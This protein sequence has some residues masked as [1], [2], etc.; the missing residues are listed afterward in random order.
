MKILHVSGAMGWGGNEQQMID[1]IP[2]LNKLDVVNIVF[3]VNRSILHLEC[4]S[5]GI[6]FI[7]AKE[8]KLNKLV[9]YRYL[10]SI[11]REIKPDIIH[12][13]TS[14]SLTVY[15]ISDLFFG[16]KTKAV[17]SKKGMGNSSS[18]L[19]KFK[20]NYIN[21]K[22]IICVSEAVKKSFSTIISKNNIHKLKVVYDGINLNRATIKNNINIRESYKIADD[23]FIIGNIANHV[24]AKDLNTLINTMNC[25]VNEMGIRNIHL[26]QV[27]KFSNKLTPEIQNLISVYKLHDFVTLTDFQPNALGFL[28][29]FDLYVMSSEREGLP[30][31][32]FEAFLKKIPVVSTKAGGIPEAIIHGFNGYLSEIR[33]YNNL[34]LN[35]QDLL[36]NQTRREEFVERSNTIFFEKFTAENT[37]KNT[38]KIYKA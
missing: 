21:I 16:L 38:L 25:L 33:D 22:T 1:M 4:Q 7:A 37:A 29:Q 13:H 10:K 31:T 28:E 5:Q 34:A 6:N 19:S 14:D 11:V 26:L 24:K 17:F 30:L 32:V 36:S 18:I 20:Y 23:I 3:G 2:E 9:N 15:T 27:G 35:I 12:L 8:N